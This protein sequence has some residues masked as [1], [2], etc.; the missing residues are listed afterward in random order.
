MIFHR[1]GAAPADLPQKRDARVDHGDH[2]PMSQQDTVGSHGHEMY[3]VG[4]LSRFRKTRGRRIVC[5]SPCGGT[6]DLRSARGA[7]RAGL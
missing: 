4:R 2:A 1:M 7:D 3:P 6:Y 5:T